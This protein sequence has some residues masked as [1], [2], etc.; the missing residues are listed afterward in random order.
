MLSPLK[1]SAS[2]ETNGINLA[3]LI[4]RPVCV[5]NGVSKVTYGANA[6]KHAYLGVC[7]ISEPEANKGEKRINFAGNLLMLHHDHSVE[8][9]SLHDNGNQIRKQ[10]IQARAGHDQP[11]NGENVVVRRSVFHG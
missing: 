10:H 3:A 1:L 7:S 9:V 4:G 11:T 8:Q 5:D 2:T 6:V